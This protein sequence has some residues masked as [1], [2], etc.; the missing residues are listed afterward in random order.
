MDWG[1]PLTS[2]PRW[3]PGRLRRMRA[4]PGAVFRGPPVAQ[5]L[6]RQWSPTDLSSGPASA[7]SQSNC[8]STSSAELFL[9]VY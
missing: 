6:W 3:V 4:R 5:T 9:I 8:L 1:G 7:R 2:V